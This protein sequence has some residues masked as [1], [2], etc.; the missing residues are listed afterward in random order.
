MNT[1]LDRLFKHLAW[2]DRELLTR[3]EQ[4][5]EPPVEPFRLLAHVLAAE[6]IWLA[7][8]HSRDS[9]SFPVW[10]R[11]FGPECRK[12]SEKNHAG[13]RVLL[14]STAEADL[15][16]LIAYQNSKGIAF[17][18]SLGD[19]LLHVALH[20]AHHRGQ[21]ATFMRLAGLEPVDTE[22]ITFCRRNPQDSPRDSVGTLG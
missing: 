18:T 22:F 7:R 13:Y 17:R 14:E 12:L 8:I 5:S 10:P 3:L 20:G 6:H 2:A 15:K 16:S 4:A 19:L 11:L 1:L 9:S 21:V